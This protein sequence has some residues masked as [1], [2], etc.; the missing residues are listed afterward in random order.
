MSSGGNGSN[1]ITRRTALLGLAAGSAMLSASDLARAEDGWD[2]IVADA[3]KEGHVV[4]YSAFVGMA[5]HETLKKDF[6]ANYGI[7]VEVLEARAS[8]IRERIR[9]ERAAGLSPG[10]VSETGRPPTTLQIEKDHVLEPF[11][12]LPSLSRLKPD[13][14]A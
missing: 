1:G 6:Q 3:K 7:T 13:F 11:G 9:I 12:P 4:L 2:K 5:A 8:E 10:D 14:H